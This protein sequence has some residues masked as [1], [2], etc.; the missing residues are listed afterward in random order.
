MKRKCLSAAAILLAVS[1]AGAAWGLETSFT[2]K[3]ETHQIVSPVPG[4]LDVVTPYNKAIS[5]HQLKKNEVAYWV[6]DG[7]KYI[8]AGS[9]AYLWC[10]VYSEKSGK[11]SYHWIAITSDALQK[12]LDLSLEFQGGVALYQL[13]NDGRQIAFKAYP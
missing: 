10:R 9:Y 11:S 2:K 12:A 4:S 13:T 8:T 3:G 7:G 1:L 6:P 5:L